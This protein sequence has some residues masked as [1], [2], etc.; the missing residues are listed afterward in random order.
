MQHVATLLL[1]TSTVAGA[2][3]TGFL[4]PIVGGYAANA[5]LVPA[6]PAADADA[7]AARCVSYGPA[8]I[9][10]NLCGS[11]PPFDCGIGGWGMEYNFVDASQCSYFRRIIPRDDSPAPRAVSFVAS[12]PPPLA[13]TLA[14]EGAIGGAFYRHADQYL[15]VR[16]PLDMLHWFAARA[17]ANPVGQCFGWDGWIKGSATGNYLMGAGSFLKHVDDA[18][19]RASVETV[20]A[21]IRSYQNKSSGWIWAFNETD[22]DADNLPDYCAGWVTRGLLDAAVAGV[23]DALELARESISLF[24]NHSSLPFFLPANNGPNPSPERPSGWNNVTNGGYGQPRGHMI[25]MQ[26]Q[27]TIKHTLMAMSPAG[28]QS[29][30]DVA[31]ELYEEGWWLNALIAE[32]LTAIWHRQFF[33]HNYEVTSFEAML[34]LYILTGNTTYFN[35][36]AAAWK[37]LRAHWILPGGSFSLNEGSYYPPDS[38]YIGFTGT[39]VAGHHDHTAHH[40]EEGGA[41]GD[42]YFHSTC[43][44]Q[45]GESEPRGIARVQAPRTTDGGPN[46]N[47]PPTGEL[48]GNV[49]WALL[50]QRFHR[51]FPTNETF[52]NEI[53]RSII[54]VGLAALGDIGSGGQG[55]NGTGIRY[56]A[57]QHKYKQLPAMHASCCEGQGTR[58]FGSLPS[59]L[60][61][62]VNTPT[63]VT[64]SVDI[65]AQSSMTFDLPASCGGGQGSIAVRTA[66]PEG[67]DVAID[68]T[69]PAACSALS[70]SLRMPA[71]LAA[72]GGCQ[73]VVVNGGPSVCGTPGTYLTVSPSSGFPQGSTLISFELP[74]ALVSLKYDGLSQL[75]PYSRYAFLYGPVLLSAQGPWNA[76]IDA[77]VLP[78]GIDPTN[79]SAFL[80]KAGA[81]N[82]TVAGA[83]NFTFKP[84]YQV[85]GA[86]E[87]FS[88]YPCFAV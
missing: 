88:N 12:L 47:D 76:T 74:M 21:G 69:L 43:M 81:L 72:P 20:V 22:L 30:V 6:A 78:T 71:W 49:F 52:V 61:S 39:K 85:Q 56:F 44:F 35:A 19:L 24:N 45:P 87:L 75:P 84:Y 46:D 50:N 68:L 13:V 73:P 5:D 59:F 65:Y 18:V 67:T 54:N 58:L 64:L 33:A 4:E 2:S 15:R 28:T 9:S 80:V 83:P 31:R 63:Q 3:V 10:F 8:C 27:G 32:D 1:V 60:F 40:A 82:F 77:L 14:N 62:L 11:S 36:C 86:L 48:C 34:D 79:P 41:D 66:W 26:E 16:D 37:M 53:E 25:Y 7:C 57:N 29:D 42:P 70:V 17:N 38:Y 23:P 55:P 51:L